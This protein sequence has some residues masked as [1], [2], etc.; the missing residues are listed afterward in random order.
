MRKESKL[1]GAIDLL[2]GSILDESEFRPALA[3][4]AE[5]ADARGAYHL[6]FDRTK[7]AAVSAA[8]VGVDPDAQSEY[9]D[10]YSSQDV[11]V[12]AALDK[13]VGSLVTE[14]TLLDQDV[15][16]ASELYRAFLKRYDIPHFLA[17]WTQKSAT[18]LSAFAIQR[19]A[20]Q[21]RF[22]KSDE[23][24]LAPLVPHLL[25]ALRIRDGLKEIRAS[26]AAYSAVIDRLPFGVVTLNWD[27]SVIE[28]SRVAQH[29][30][31]V[32]HVIHCRQGRV[33]AAR[34]EDDS[35]LQ[36]AIYVAMTGGARGELPG[37]SLTLSDRHRQRT[38]RVTVLPVPRPHPSMSREPGCML[39]MVDLNALGTPSVERVM[40]LLQLT[41]AEA[42]LAC[43]LCKGISL[44]E[45]AAALGLSINT[46]KTQLKSI[47]ARTG[48]RSHVDLVKALLLSGLA[49][50]VSDSETSHTI[51]SYKQSRPTRRRS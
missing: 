46:C 39:V 48:C 4:V 41:T 35:R 7:G 50:G 26:H 51:G 22:L 3:T 23:E 29:L 37:R 28:V 27:R 11:R 32:S 10:H 12:P 18:H 44:R 5:F 16:C 43:E 2:Y 47:Y 8:S 34:L 36:R 25:R 49:L 33:H 14:H 38:L 17:L 40:K 6:I 9:L 45:A 31:Q 1:L 42:R 24:Q 21:G 19:A 15:F 20:Q 13:P 30:F